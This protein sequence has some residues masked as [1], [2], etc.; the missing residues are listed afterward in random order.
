[1]TVLRDLG[2]LGQTAVPRGARL[3][4]GARE[5]PL[6]PLDGRHSLAVEHVA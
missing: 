5:E 2:A 1:M 4:S 6:E 3:V